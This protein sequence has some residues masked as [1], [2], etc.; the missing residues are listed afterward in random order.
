MTLRHSAPRLL[1][2][3]IQYV[4]NVVSESCNSFVTKLMLPET[5]TSFIASIHSVRS[6]WNEGVMQL[7]RDASDEYAPWQQQSGVES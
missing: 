6:E 1:R 7:I 4:A 5:D 3:F 2:P